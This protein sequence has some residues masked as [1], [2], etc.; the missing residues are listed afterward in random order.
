MDQG[1]VEYVKFKLDRHGSLVPEVDD[2]NSQDSFVLNDVIVAGTGVQ[3]TTC[4]A[5]YGILP[6]YAH[7]ESNEPVNNVIFEIVDG[8]PAAVT[9]GVNR[10][11]FTVPAGGTFDGPI[12]PRLCTNTGG[13][14][15]DV[16]TTLTVNAIIS[17][18]FLKFK[19]REA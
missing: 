18:G 7:V 14:F 19:L 1:Y 10:W 13:T 15:L 12:Y 6:I 11:L 16:V 8:D 17:I 4:P 2:V 5:G 3:I 9:P